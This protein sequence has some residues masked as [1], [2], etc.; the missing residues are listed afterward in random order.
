MCKI[1]LKTAIISFLIFIV[2]QKESALWE[3]STKKNY[4]FLSNNTG[5]DFVNIGVH[6]LE[7]CWRKD[8]LSGRG[9]GPDV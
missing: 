2:R 3:A 5:A 7:I 1:I 6:D 8:G 4:A 9:P